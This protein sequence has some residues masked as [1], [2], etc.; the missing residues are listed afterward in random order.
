M[1]I[2]T[3][4]SAL[5]AGTPAAQRPS[6]AHELAYWRAGLP[7][8]AGVDEVGR[9]PLAGPV[10]AAAV[11]LPPFFDAPWLSLVRDSKLLSARRR[12]ELAALIRRDAV[13]VGVGGASATDIDRDGLTAAIR[14]AAT[15]ALASLGFPPDHLLLDAMLLRDQPLDQTGLIDGDAR[16]VSIACAA[17]V[18]KVE[19]DA[20]MARLDAVYP[21]YAFARHKGYGTAA[22]LCALDRLGPSPVHRRSFA[23]VR[24]RMDLP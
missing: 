19:R 1:P 12:A 14:A 10:M 8:V 23:P 24:L 7:R 16:C 22:H 6:L 2:V 3:V 13:A 5:T 18:A 9:G 15:A 21:G 4:A 20:L 11:V 17:I